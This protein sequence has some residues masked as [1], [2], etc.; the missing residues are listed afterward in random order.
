MDLTLS[1]RRG[2]IGKALHATAYELE[3]SA[4]RYVVVTA[5]F[6]LVSAL[7]SHKHGLDK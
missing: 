5:S 7:L 2:I 1:G 6:I 4:A 3:K